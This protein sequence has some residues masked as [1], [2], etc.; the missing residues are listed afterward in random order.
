MKRI[1]LSFVLVI[2]AL[3]SNAQAPKYVLFEHFTQASCGPC[4]AQN[5]SFVN[6]VLIPNPDK[7]RHIAYHT[8]WPGVDPMNAYNAPQVADRVTLY[9]VSGV[10]NMVLMGNKKQGAPANFSQADVDNIFGETSP[11]KIE[12]QQTD[13]GDSMHVD[14]VV[15]SIGV[16]P[17]GTH[18]LRIAVIEKDITY[19]TPPGTN[20]EL[21]FPNVF[22]RMFP[23][24]T[25][26]AVTFAPQGSS[27]TYSFSY[28]KEA[29]WNINQIA[30]VAFIQNATTK[31]I[32]NCGT[33]FDPVINATLTPAPVNA[34]SGNSTTATTFNLTAGNSG[35]STES[36]TYT[37]T[38]N[39]PSNWSSYITVNAVDYP[40]VATITTSPSSNN[41]LSIVVEPG[42]SPFI[43][44][45]TLKATS[46]TNPTAPEMVTQVYVVSGVT[47]VIVSNS[48]GKGDGTGGSAADWEADYS[49][50]LLATGCTGLGYANEV[51]NNKCINAGA[52]TG[53]SSIYFN[54]GWTF[55][56]LSDEIVNAYSTFLSN[57]G[58]LY[59]AGQDLGW[60]TWDAAG[61]GTTATKAFY[62][63]YLNASYVSDG[64]TSQ[65]AINPF[66]NEIYNSTSSV[67]LIN[68]YGNGTNGP[69]FYPDII[70]PVGL[71]IPIY[72]YDADNTK[73]AG[74]RATD[75]NYKTVYIAP[76]IEMY[77]TTASK[78]LVMNITY[79]WFHGLISS[80]EY[81]GLLNDL[82][83]A[84][85]NPANNEIIIPLLSTESII[86]IHDI[87]GREITRI[88]SSNTLAR[89]NTTN[90]AQGL[91]TYTIINNLSQVNKGR[92]VIS[93]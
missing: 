77:G 85:P 86:I 42:T 43:A 61:S 36:F 31:E 73:I 47:D 83:N 76:G 45:Y 88:N 26:A 3:Y 19:S 70:N 39:A 68:Y 17:S 18:K 89:I 8:S 40:N 74:V 81:D 9:S 87:N 67:S 11:I 28:Y 21:E 6:G 15:K 16:P 91:Y 58:N 23:N 78:N 30:T 35:S 65:S 27:F 79:Q 71:G 24:T 1:V 80:V 75:G 20:G 34:Q 12:V 82:G 62:T 10:P 72:Y 49:T 48:S 50:A 4:A 57:G 22:R 51:I 41:N 63:N 92:F 5:P 59:I 44:T 84:Y 2:V 37:L 32:V 7:V 14:I 55:P 25:G 38:S 93:H 33:N 64:S 29:V 56:G 66:S 60:E 69:N 46:V 13:I 53:V 54:V 90:F 52:Y